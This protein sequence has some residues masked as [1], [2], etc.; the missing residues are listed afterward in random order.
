MSLSWQNYQESMNFQKLVA[1][2]KGS[3]TLLLRLY[4]DNVLGHLN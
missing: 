4:K 2:A 1:K 3:G